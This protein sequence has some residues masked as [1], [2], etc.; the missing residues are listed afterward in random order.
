LP[1]R[2][3][4]LSAEALVGL[5]VRTQAVAVQE[6]DGFAVEIQKL[7]LLQALHSGLATEAIAEKEI[8]IAA[9]EIQRGTGGGEIG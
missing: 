3:A 6:H 8:P 1:A 5:V 7:W 9:D 4:G 2:V